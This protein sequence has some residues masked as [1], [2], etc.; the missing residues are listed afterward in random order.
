M[1]EYKQKVVMLYMINGQ[2]RQVCCWCGLVVTGVQVHCSA[3]TVN[4]DGILDVFSL[5]GPC[6]MTFSQLY[7]SHLLY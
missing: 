6:D 7:V 3:H 1:E 5:I 2:R 4:Q